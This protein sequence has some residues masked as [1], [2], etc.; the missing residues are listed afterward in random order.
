MV[1]GTGTAKDQG[2]AYYWMALAADGGLPKAQHRL[3][4][5]EEELEPAALRAARQRLSKD[6]LTPVID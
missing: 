4:I 3:R 5:L 6:P 1:S 2:S